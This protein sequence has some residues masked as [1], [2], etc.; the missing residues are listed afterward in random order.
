MP[1]SGAQAVLRDGTRL[2]PPMGYP[3]YARMTDDNLDAIIAW[4]RTVPPKG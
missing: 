4:L 2:K 1:W 3:Y